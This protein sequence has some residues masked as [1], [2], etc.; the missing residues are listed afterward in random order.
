MATT[1]EQRDRFKGFVTKNNIKQEDIT[2]D[3]ARQV[4]DTGTYDG[5]Q[6]RVPEVPTPTQEDITEQ[7]Q[8]PVAAVQELD[9]DRGSWVRDDNA[10]SLSQNADGGFAIWKTWENVENLEYRDREKRFFDE[11]AK[12][13]ITVDEFN[14]REENN[15]W[16]DTISDTLVENTIWDQVWGDIKQ[17][18]D[19]TEVVEDAVVSPD[20]VE[21][22]PKAIAE[23]KRLAEEQVASE[24]QGAMDSGDFGAMNDIIINNPAKRAA[25]NAAAKNHFKTQKN[26]AFVNKYTGMN[27]NQ[28]YSAFKEGTIVPNSEQYALL[29][30]EQRTAFN[31]FVELQDKTE[32]IGDFDTNA[33]QNSIDFTN[34]D[35]ITAWLFDTSII[36][37]VR[38]IRNNPKVS[39]L[40]TKLNTK[41]EEIKKFDR[42][43]QK[44]Q[45][46][47]E[48]ELANAWFTPNMIRAKLRDNGQN[49]RDERYDMMSDYRIIQGDLSSEQWRIEDD[50][51]LL[52]IEDAATKKKY[53]FMYGEYKENRAEMSSIAKIEFEAQNQILSENRALESQ[54]ELA[55]FKQSLI[56]TDVTV[57]KWESRHDGIYAL[58]SDGTAELVVNGGMTKLPDGVTM[59]TYIWEDGEP[60]SETYNSNWDVMWAST[61]NTRL[62]QK[63]TDL[64]NTPAGTIIPTRLS[65]TTNTNG[66]KECAEY[67][68]DIFASEVGQRMWNT[69]ASK[70]AVATEK[71][72][73]V[74]SLA[75]WQPDPNGEFAKFGHAWVIVWE[76]EDG[77]QWHIKSSNFNWDWA[78]SVDAV[79]KGVIS[80]YKTT[81]MYEK[82]I[83]ETDYSI[84]QKKFLEETKL[85]DFSNK[86][87][88]K[89][90]AKSLWL[91]AEDVFTFKSVTLD[92]QKSD[93]FQDVLNGIDL[94]IW[95]G[96][97]D[98]LSDALWIFSTARFFKDETERSPE[99]Y[100]AGTDA[101][102]FETQ[103]NSLVSKLTIKNLD[104]MT[105]ILTDKDL[106]VLKGA[107]TALSLNMS[108]KEFKK[109]LDKIEGAVKNSM[110]TLGKLWDNFFTDDSGKKWSKAWLTDEL[111]DLIDSGQLTTEEARKYLS[112][113][114]IKLD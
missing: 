7:S 40:T 88:V 90:A 54:K 94:V 104:K 107:E 25:F 44:E 112:D 8:W 33:K 87:E 55:T 97:W 78:I 106:E 45:D 101:A 12:T 4:L 57:D 82:P 23:E 67:V 49:M 29:P 109:E 89:A 113:N 20:V 5:F 35:A 6:A 93:E 100:A 103:F 51:K 71:N 16:Q 73:G 37:K 50:I 85:E 32:N 43:F 69:Y 52:E 2:A 83:E 79:P 84:A 24:F 95:A 28:M 14:K 64:L 63:Q 15:L 58:K 75:V 61:T 77:T 3:Q 66:G 46:A 62:N 36:D 65:Q 39:D 26:A 68:N 80:G 76:S 70:L 81:S 30:M 60:I 99:K 34:I 108:E 105:G 10:R 9:T 59:R 18:I 91:T 47:L 48:K 41:G 17:A 1:K 38:E 19:S 72:G 21:E 56:W 110:E 114:N 92:P 102:D 98:G 27:N 42:N 11:S 13:G 86:K 74:G 31:K 22:D 53:E 96:G 111:A